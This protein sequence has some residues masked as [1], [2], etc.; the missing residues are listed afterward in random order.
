MP[1]Q[2]A[3]PPFFRVRLHGPVIVELVQRVP[4]P[5]GKARALLAYVAA[6]G[7]VHQEIAA[8]ALWP[9]MPRGVGTQGLRNV[10]HR[11]HPRLVV[12]DGPL[13]RLAAGTTVDYYERQGALLAEWP[14]EEW[15]LHLRL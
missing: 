1:G 3:T 7:P 6:Y 11:Q 14:H 4:V 10:L 5:H 15:A 12:R 13:L 9:G 8:E 2:E